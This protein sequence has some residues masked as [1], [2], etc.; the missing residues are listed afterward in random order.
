MGK[1]SAMPALHCSPIV[2]QLHMPTDYSLRALIS[3]N[4]TQKDPF[5]CIDIEV[6]KTVKMIQWAILL[7]QSIC[8][9][10]VLFRAVFQTW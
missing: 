1:H 3:N 5:S 10:N 6:E 2:A 4:I 9:V 7:V 8:S